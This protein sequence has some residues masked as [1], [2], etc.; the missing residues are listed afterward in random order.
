[1]AA[2]SEA[3]VERLLE[4][5]A[6]GVV[7]AER[8]EL[9]ALL[10]KTAAK[11]EDP[12]LKKLGRLSTSFVDWLGAEEPLVKA[13]ASCILANIA[14]IEEGQEAVFNAGGITPLLSLLREHQDTKVKT[15]ATAAIQNLTF[16][17]AACCASVLQARGDKLLKRLLSHSTE[18]VA[19]FAAGAIAN[20]QL[21]RGAD[22][23]SRG[24][25]I[26]KNAGCGGPSTNEQTR[27]ATSLQAVW[28]GH[29]GRRWYADM[30]RWSEKK[31]PRY[32][33]FSVHAVRNE[34]E[35]SQKRIG[36]AMNRLSVIPTQ[37]PLSPPTRAE[38]ARLAPPSLLPPLSRH[39]PLP[40]LSSP[41][42]P[43]P[44]LLA[45]RPPLGLAR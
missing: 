3:E 38:S 16:K 28:R 30:K 43:S 37:K 11:A 10:S 14:F 39:A 23:A 5:V 2:M 26:K 27:A 1:M 20:L 13:Y 8:Y 33:T 17:N 45:P 32:S 21:Y 31:K 29:R 41:K 40:P 24:E 9:A 22:D 15:H 35:T 19:Q 44:G 6:N 12:V 4:R 18:D 7:G 36:P 34:L 25:R 42:L